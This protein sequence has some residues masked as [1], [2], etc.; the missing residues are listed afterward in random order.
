MQ[1][2][3]GNGRTGPAINQAPLVSDRARAVQQQGAVSSPMKSRTGIHYPSM[4]N[5]LSFRSSL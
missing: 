3:E 1:C 4:S 2:M 5:P